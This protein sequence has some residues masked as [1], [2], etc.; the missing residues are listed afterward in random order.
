MRGATP[1]YAPGN[2]SW[3]ELSSPDPETSATFYRELVA[4]ITTEPMDMPIGRFANMIDAQ[5]AS[6]SVMQPGATS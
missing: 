3:V 1:E 5:G 2:L 4:A 6:F